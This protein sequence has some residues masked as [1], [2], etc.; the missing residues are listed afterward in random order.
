[1]SRK[2]EKPSL[3]SF[4][5]GAAPKSSVPSV[6]YGVSDGPANCAEARGEKSFC[7][8]SGLGLGLA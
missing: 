2:P 3:S 4:S 5:V 7:F 8:V 1:M 6:M